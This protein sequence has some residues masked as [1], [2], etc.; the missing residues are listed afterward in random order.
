MP[1]VRNRG[2]NNPYIEI[3]SRLSRQE[4]QWCLSKFN[5][6]VNYR[7]EPAMF[8][9]RHNEHLKQRGFPGISQDLKR[10]PRKKIREC[11]WQTK[12]PLIPKMLKIKL[13]RAQDEY[14]AHTLNSDLREKPKRFWSYIKNKRQVQIG[15]P[16]LCENGRVMPGSLSKAEI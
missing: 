1:Y 4:V 10:S 8:Q 11:L 5:F 15:V 6:C 13:R 9:I 12:I 3:S 2:P 14:I 7:E 16:P